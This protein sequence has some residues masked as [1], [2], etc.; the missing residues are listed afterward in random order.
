MGMS[1]VNECGFFGMDKVEEKPWYLC[2]WGFLVDFFVYLFMTDT[3]D[4]DCV[5]T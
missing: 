3:G 2:G 4:Y 5:A 1:Y